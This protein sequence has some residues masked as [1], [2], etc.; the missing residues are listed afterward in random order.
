MNEN[1]VVSVE[2]CVI[3]LQTFVDCTH[4]LLFMCFVICLIII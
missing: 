2:Q 1:I 3:P 4:I